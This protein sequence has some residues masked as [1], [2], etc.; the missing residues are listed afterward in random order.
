MLTEEALVRPSSNGAAIR[1]ITE[2]TL[3]PQIESAIAEL[4]LGSHSKLS[5]IT[6]SAIA[7]L[8]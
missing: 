4:Q 5:I 1:L 3:I 8:N 6:F 7:D 2:Q